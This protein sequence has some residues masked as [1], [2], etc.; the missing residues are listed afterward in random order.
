MLLRQYK[1]PAGTQVWIVCPRTHTRIPNRQRFL[2]IS[3]P[4]GEE[5]FPYPPLYGVKHIGSRILG[6]HR[7]LYLS[8]GYDPRR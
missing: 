2:P 7:H 1:L 8:V 6:I 5:L 3:I 4:V